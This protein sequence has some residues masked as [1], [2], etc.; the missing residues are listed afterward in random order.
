MASSFETVTHRNNLMFLT[1]ISARNV[2]RNGKLKD[3]CLNFSKNI[4]KIMLVSNSNNINVMIYTG[5][6]NVIIT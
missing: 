2:F 3:C 1:L 4:V 6:I 5:I